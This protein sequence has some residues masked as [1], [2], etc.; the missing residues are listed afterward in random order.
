MYTYKYIQLNINLNTICIHN[1]IYYG[2]VVHGMVQ[3]MLQK[4]HQCTTVP[5]VSVYMQTQVVLWYCG[6]VGLWYC[7]WYCG[8]VVHWDGTSKS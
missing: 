6:T 8:T 2:T 1:E 3:G 4:T 7:G 5:Y